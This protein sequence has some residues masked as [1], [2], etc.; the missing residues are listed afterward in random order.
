MAGLKE[1]LGKLASPGTMLGLLA[2]CVALS[3]TALAAAPI[4]SSDVINNS[5]RGIDVKNK[6]LTKRDFRGSVRG[7]RGPRGLRGA[8]G[9]AGATNVV[10]RVGSPTHINGGGNYGGAT[11]QCNQGER[12]T[13]GGLRV[14]QF[15]GLHPVG[16]DGQMNE[17]HPLTE[18]AGTTPTGW[19]VQ[20]T[21]GTIA[22]DIAAYVVCASP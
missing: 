1:R 12:A 14:A 20:Y 3:G 21:S 10:T 13:G 15:H 9:A 16:G 11:V 19:E 7:P 4:G 17:S 6:S 5:L 18:G 2:L 22:V 8:T